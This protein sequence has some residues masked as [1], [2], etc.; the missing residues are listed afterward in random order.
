MDCDG[1]E[2]NSFNRISLPYAYA[3][4]KY[5]IKYGDDAIE[6][7]SDGFAIIDAASGDVVKEYDNYYNA[8]LL[9]DGNWYVCK[10][11]E[12]ESMATR[13]ILSQM[14]LYTCDH[15]DYYDDEVEMKTS[16]GFF[17]DE[18]FEPLYGGKEY[19]LIAQGEGL[20]IVK[21]IDKNEK[22]EY[23]VLDETGELFNVVDE[24][25]E[26]RIAV[27][28]KNG[29]TINDSIT[30]FRQNDGTIGFANISNVYDVLYYS[31]EGELIGDSKVGENMFASG[32]DDL[33][34]FTVEEKE[35]FF[36]EYYTITKLGIKN[37]DNEV[38]LPAVYSDLL[39]LPGTENIMINNDKGC[40]IIRL[41]VN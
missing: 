20:Y 18:N 38:I 17:V 31:K 39:F 36:D 29:D 35:E 11:V 10:T 22:N 7:V 28:E 13:K 5:F 19:R 40:G 6:D 37:N 8:I 26:K 1:K 2:V 4:D 3:G 15:P 32:R 41:E 23:I 9:D 25:L 33:I 30:V 34:I 27:Y 14:N 24:A 16:K 21:T 12:I